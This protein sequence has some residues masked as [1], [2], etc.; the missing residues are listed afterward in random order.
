MAE[1]EALEPFGKGF[2]PPIF[3]DQAIIERCQ[4]M[5]PDSPHLT[6]HVTFKPPALVRVVWFNGAARA[7]T[8]GLGQGQR[9]EQMYELAA[10]DYPLGPGYDRLARDVAIIA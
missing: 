10:S 9:I 5:K 6:L 8:L 2:P 7:A 4:P 1:A 3:C